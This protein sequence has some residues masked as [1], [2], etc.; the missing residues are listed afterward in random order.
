MHFSRMSV[1]RIVRKISQ[2]VIFIK[3]NLSVCCLPVA[4]VIDRSVVQ[5]VV[6]IGLLVSNL[7]V[8]KVFPV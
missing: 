8:Y 6:G 1:L 7:H 4:A 3:I 2:S 5:E